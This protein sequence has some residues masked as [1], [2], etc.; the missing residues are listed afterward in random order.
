MKKSSKTKLYNTSR[1]TTF[2]L[3]IS[4]SDFV[5]TIQ[6]LNWKIWQLQS[7]LW[8]SKWFQMEQSSTTKLKNPLRSTNF[9]LVI[10]PSDKLVA[11]MFTIGYIFHIVTYITMWEMYQYVNNVCYHLVK[12]ISVF[13]VKINKN[14]RSTTFVCHFS[15]RLYLNN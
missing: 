13:Y 2:I 11:Y 1:S 3:A 6:N 12:I 9:V 5:W 14:M 7:T 15:I 10:T 4:Q 8:D